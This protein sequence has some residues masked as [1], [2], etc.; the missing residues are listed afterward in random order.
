M[1]GDPSAKVSEKRKGAINQ[2]AVFPERRAHGPAAA[3]VAGDSPG[4]SRG[5]GHGGWRGFGGG[6]ACQLRPGHSTPSAGSEPLPDRQGDRVMRPPAR[7][8]QRPGADSPGG[9]GPAV[10]WALTS[11]SHMGRR[12]LFSKPPVC[13]SGRR[14]GHSHQPAHRPLL[15][16]WGV[17]PERGLAL[18]VAAGAVACRTIRAWILFKNILT[19]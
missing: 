18:L 1:H 11:G 8:W 13:G 19:D 6:L 15:G 2:R 16:L 7:G 5:P 9:A 3:P 12:S 4:S 10:A 17:H 14:P